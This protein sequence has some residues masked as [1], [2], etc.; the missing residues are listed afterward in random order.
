MAGLREL[1]AGPNVALYAVSPDT[2]ELSRALIEKIESDGKGEMNFLLLSDPGSVT[3]D[4][5]GLR[6][7]AYAGEQIDGVPHP[8]VFVIDHEGRIRWSRVESDYTQRA[9]LDEIRAALGASEPS[10]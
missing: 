6:D 8:A 9:S 10:P 3:I 5:W 4:R 2:A 1:G 7:P